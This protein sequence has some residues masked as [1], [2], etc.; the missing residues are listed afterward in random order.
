VRT[1]TDRGRAVVTV[2]GRLDPDTAAQLRRAL[3]TLCVVCLDVLVLDLGACTGLSDEGLQVLRDAAGRAG[4]GGCRVQ[5]A[6]G[7]P[8]F[9]ATLTAAGFRVVPAE[10]ARWQRQ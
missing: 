6:T 8:A 4:R 5:V 3:L 1:R 7:H 2:T 10:Q 9:M